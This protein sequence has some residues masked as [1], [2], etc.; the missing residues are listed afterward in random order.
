[1]YETEYRNVAVQRKKLSILA[2]CLGVVLVIVAAGALFFGN[3]VVVNS[4]IYDRNEAVL[5]L[6]GEGIAVEHYNALREKLPDRTIYWDVPFQNGYHDNNSTELTI[7]RI[8][9]EDM[10]L[11]GY[12][13]DVKTIH[14]E[15]C[16][17]YAQLQKL[18][19]QRPDLEVLYTITIDGKEYAQDAETIT[20][21]NLTD[22]EVENTDYLP[23]LK[24]VDAT[25]CTDYAQLAALRQRHPEC[26]VAYKI[27]IGDEEYPL[28][29]STLNLKNQDLSQLLERMA[30]LPAMKTVHLTDPV[31]DAATMDALRSTYPNVTI[32]SE[33]VGVQVSQDG[34]EVDL[35]G[36][37]LEKV[38][39]VDK[40]MP[41]Y[42]DAERVYLGQQAIDHDTIAAFRDAKRQDYK[43]VWT[44]MCGS[45]PLRTD[46]TYFQPIQYSVYYFFD[47][48]C[49]N[50]RY[51]EDM[52]SVD[53]GHMAVRDISWVEGT[54]NLK[55]LVLTM[56]SVSDLTP[57]STCKNLIWL[58]LF[59]NNIRDY[60]P[61][62]GCTA[63][64]DL[65]IGMTYGDATVLAEMTWLKNLFCIGIKYQY[66]T[67]LQEALPDTNINTTG[68]GWRQLQNYYDHR[69]LMGMRYMPG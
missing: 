26:D 25:A 17:D 35:S 55:Y 30:F 42:P 16:E 45:I 60:T 40:Y 13:Y 7:T 19:S 4:Q 46:A 10:K 41:F 9:D 31:G 51:C 50:L 52:L 27:V 6:R 18:Q 20:V 2:I 5:D 48:D 8:S 57:L 21:T 49:V 56:T 38:E 43:V 47:E 64:Q 61:L 44:V 24:S 69:D 15:D 54:P 11:L 65:E 36:I 34:K 58:E 23:Q 68:Y 22:E 63:L 29:T 59:Q 14:A 53:L 12:F 1:M 32:T 39:D 62:L 66:Q 3:Y 67:F 33:L 37:K 28:D